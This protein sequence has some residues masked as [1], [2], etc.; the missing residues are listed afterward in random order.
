MKDWKKISKGNDEVRVF[1][2]PVK[3]IHFDIIKAEWINEKQPKDVAR[4]MF[5]NYADLTQQLLE[6]DVSACT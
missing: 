1:S 5:E 2:K 4:Y 6:T 3:G